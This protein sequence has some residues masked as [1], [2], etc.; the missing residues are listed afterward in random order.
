IEA[1]TDH[2]VHLC[3][4]SGSV[5]NFSILKHALANHRRLRHTWVYSNKTADD[6]IFRHQLE[7][8]VAE[9]PRNLRVIHTLTRETD[10]DPARSAGDVR[11]GRVTTTLLREAIPDPSSCI[12]Y[13][14]GPAISVWDRAAARLRGTA[15][16]PRFLETVLAG[17]AEVGVADDRI[18]HES[19][20]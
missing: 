6:I 4:G 2:L 16:A 15:A 5:P 3:A 12:V 10:S 1:Q 8:L 7:K 17:L 13:A 9:H 11:R 20:G 18:H 14:C 19:Y